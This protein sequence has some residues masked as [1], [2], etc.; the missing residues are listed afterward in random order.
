MFQY[1]TL[2][3]FY[4]NRIFTFESKKIR[5]KLTFESKNSL[6]NLFFQSK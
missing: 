6:Y 4:T 2:L 3:T 1:N 5:S